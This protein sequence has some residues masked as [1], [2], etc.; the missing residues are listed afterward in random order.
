MLEITV[1]ANEVFNEETQEFIPSEETTLRL[2]HSL[3]SLSKWESIWEKPFLGKE[4]KTEEEIFSYVKCMTLDSK[5]PPEVFLNLSEANFK[6]IN[7]HIDAKMSATWFNEKA[8]KPVGAK[9]IVTAELIYY[10]MIALNIPMTCEAW[11]LSRL[12]TLIKVCNQKNS[13][14]KK[15]SKQDLAARNRELNAARKAKLNTSG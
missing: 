2:E 6:A 12:F 15:M 7:Y 1:P 8:T 11:H 3:V 10:W 14:P 13:P 9:E 4:S 5:I